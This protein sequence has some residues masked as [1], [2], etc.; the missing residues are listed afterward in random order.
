MARR[1][2]Q[3]AF[4]ASA[5]PDAQSALQIAAGPL[6]ATS[7]PSEA[8]VIVALGG[9]GLM[10]QSLHRF[11]GTAKPIYGMNKGTVGFLM[12]EF[13]EDDLFD[14][15]ESGRAQRRASAAD[16]GLGR[17][18]RWPTRP[19]PSTKSSMLRQTYQAGEAAR[20][21]RL[22]GAH[23]GAHRRRH[24]G[25]DA[26]RIDRLQ[27]LGQRPDP[28]AQRAASGPDADLRL[29]PAA[30]ARRAAAGLCQ[31]SRSRFWRPEN[32]PVSAVADHTEFRDV[33]QRACL[34]GSQRRSG[35]AARSRPQ[36]RRAHPAR[37]I[38]LL[39]IEGMGQ[40]AD[41]NERYVMHD[42]TGTR[43][44]A[45]ISRISPSAPPSVTA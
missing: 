38:R 16:G 17:A 39:T 43:A 15:L 13:R 12:N 34:D 35:D 20:Q 18:R 22:A 45:S 14:R 3:L 9:D 19:A 21:R 41:D 33:S 28:A 6:S 7:I 29:S 37:A 10:L 23:A 44:A 27:P 1:F 40:H 5:A 26:G 30:L 32:R 11:M 31:A 8:D 36:P 24:P 2:N 4:V 42:E 25:G